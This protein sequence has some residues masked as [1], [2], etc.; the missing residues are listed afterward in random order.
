MAGENV[1]SILVKSENL[2]GAGFGEAAAA[3]EELAAKT[4]AAM[5]EYT[6]AM[7]EAGKAQ[8]HLEE[9][10]RGGVASAGELAAA[11]DKV[12]QATVRSLDAQIRLG[13]AELAQSAKAR[14]AGVAQTEL[15]AKTK[16]SGAAA[17]GAGGLFSGFKQMAG[18][19]M[20]GVGYESVK[21]AMS[22][23]KAMEMLVTQAGVPQSHLNA[24]KAGVLDLA[25]KVGFSPDSLA[26]SLYHVASNMA[27]M[28]ASSATMMKVVQTAAE[29]A[30]VGGASL[31]DVTNA[32]GAAIASGI[33]GV[34]NFSQ[35]M[36]AL[37][38][39]VGAGDMH[40]Q[41]LTEALGTGL[42]AVVK[43]Y[44]L[45]LKN[46]GA[47]LATFGDNNIRGANAAT[48]LRMAVQSLAVPAAAGKKEL[49]GMGLSMTSLARDMQTGG[50]LK[51][52]QDLQQHFE[53]VGIISHV[54]A[55]KLSDDI[56]QYGIDSKQV[57]T[58]L[59]SQGEA[60]T[61]IFGKKA[62][63]GLAV[64]MEQMDRL[65][66]KFPAITAGANNF[67]DAW[68]KTQQNLSQQWDQLRATFDA[69]MTGIGS[70]LIPVLSS[71]ASFLLRNKGI[72]ETLTPVILGLVTAFLAV[73]AAVKAFEMAGTVIG[74]LTSPVGLVIV[75]VAALAVGIYELVKHFSAV[76]H[77]AA[78]VFDWIKSH[79][80]LLTP[81]L[82]TPLGPIIALGLGI[83]ALVKH[84][85]AVEGAAKTAAGA[86]EGAWAHVWSAVVSP[87]AG[88]FNAVKSAI[89]GGFDSW[90]KSH[91]EEV[92]QVWRAV[93]GAVSAIFKAEWALT[94]SLVKTG[95]DSITAVFKTAWTIISTV[96][97]TG[98]DIMIAVLKPG[99]DVLV[100]GFETA[101]E[102]ITA[103][104]KAAWDIIAGVVKVAIAGVTSAV[105]IAWDVLAGVFS[106]FL[107]L[108]TGHWG[109]AWHDI[110]NTVT[111][112]MNAVKGFLSAAWDAIR[113]AGIAAWNALFS[114][115]KSVLGNLLGLA[116]RLPGDILHALGDLGHLLWDAGAAIIEGLIHG[117]ESM[118]GSLGNVV[119]GIGHFIASLKGPLPKDLT[120][121]VP[122]GQAIMQGLMAGIASQVP[123]LRSQLAGI[124]GTIA[125]MPG[126]GGAAAGYGAGGYG[127][128]YAGGAPIQLQ[129]MSGGASAFEQFMLLA[130]REW[131]RTKGGG[132]VQKAFGIGK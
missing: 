81:L 78:E 119:G 51:A 108:I 112:V 126:P 18:M 97:K 71:V 132:N 56:K 90:W 102:M 32:L 25:G 21:M 98:W 127:G 57:A 16:G 121:L 61:N 69:L 9:L 45:S 93:W 116:A 5:D 41:D 111:Q 26:E 105:K 59:G 101:W 117:I 74:L 99:M 82:A 95:W 67:G 91:G 130:I 94:V 66:S 76:K 48:D 114:G 20:A 2:T 122:H 24:L 62:G 83:Y 40:M 100:T 104:F 15:A 37:N 60:I 65:K 1:V 58:D 79:W 55:K 118:I 92:K 103:V 107:D 113:G 33:P 49:A 29:G 28:G 123:A 42:L 17:A 12:T 43:G 115:V 7:D 44:G 34:Q 6:V 11:Q 86:I 4:K 75:A 54:T 50:L 35:A 47:A 64:L 70:K 46:V 87:V 106:V 3:S 84:F 88:A 73:S 72:I 14:E 13:E 52:L 22:F 77:A 68:H 128:A 124:T 36:G 96:V 120:L 23:Q 10:Q 125:G 63:V 30:K 89:T 38:A 110:Q 53:R 31:V 85:G 80:V 27:S 19:A 131:V 109:K 8:A 39:I 129:V